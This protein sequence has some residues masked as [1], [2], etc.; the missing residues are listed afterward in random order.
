MN[1]YV[2]KAVEDYIDKYYKIPDNYLKLKSTDFK[3]KAYDYW[4]GQEVIKELKKY[5]GNNPIGVISDFRDRMDDYCC[6]A[7]TDD[8]ID[9]FS[10]LFEMSTWI[11][12]YLIEILY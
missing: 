12:D 8:A 9:I 3:R 4:A 5:H 11:L 2:I 1:E 7:K 6:R 10:A